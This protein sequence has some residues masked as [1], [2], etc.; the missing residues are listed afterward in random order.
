M[1]RP[2]SVY[3]N[4]Y[5]TGKLSDEK[6]A[7]IVQKEFDLRPNAIIEKL[8]LRRPIY[9]ATAAYGHFGRNEF[10]WEQTDSAE[11]LKKYLK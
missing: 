2:V 11:R 9:A 4:T 6:I 5:G 10:S 3:I 1:A 7:E 8:N